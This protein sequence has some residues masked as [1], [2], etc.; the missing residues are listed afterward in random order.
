M[1]VAMVKQVLDIC[2][3]WSSVRW[4]DTTPANLFDVWPA[5]ALYWEM[6]CLFHADWFIIPQRQTTDYTNWAVLN[7]PGQEEV[8]RKYTSGIV[9]PEQIPFED[10]DLVLSIDAILDVPPG[11]KP[12]FAYFAAEHKDKHYV[13]S[14][15]G[16]LR[17]YDLFLD[18]M[19]EAS[20]DLNSLPQAIAFPYLHD[21]ETVRSLFGRERENSI[22]I[23]WRTLA[24]LTLAEINDP[25]SN[26]IVAAAKRLEK[27]LGLPLRFGGKVFRGVYG[28][29]D[30]PHWGD[31]R[32]FLETI[33]N[34]KYYVSGGQISGAGQG[35]PEAATL[36]CICIGQK[37][38]AYHRMVCHP[39]CLSESLIE[40]PKI[41]RKIINSV[42]KHEEILDWQDRVLR[43][44]F[45]RKPMSM[46]NKAI[47]WKSEGGRMPV[48]TPDDLQGSVR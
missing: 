48:R 5:R 1:K 43:E 45:L 31:S 25:W 38:K 23:D 40:M 2:G 26:A 29:N 17:N 42:D 33:S 44:E 46:L 41:V 3:P 4:Q 20:G 36:G 24:T 22:G 12:L 6:A 14:R 13:E 35:V 27:V 34:C 21:I 18:H 19:M 28:V 7:H 15:Q 32:H 30:P 10:Y 9:Q 11:A 8:V 37:D 47:Q 16:P 39:E